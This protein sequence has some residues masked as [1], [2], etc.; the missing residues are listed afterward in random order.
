VREILASLFMWLGQQGFA[1]LPAA[2]GYPAVVRRDGPALLGMVLGEERL[3]SMSDARIRDMS[4]QVAAAY[5]PASGT[6]LLHE[7]L[8]LG[9]VYGRSVLVHELVHLLQFRAR[10]DETVPCLAAL[11]RRAYA[12]Q[13]SYLR[14][15]GETALMDDASIARRSAC[16]P[17]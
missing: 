12:V 2:H 7:A 14:A 8:D 16:P 9:T 3:A 13:R 1:D 6:V 17:S 11:E 15:H 10:A 4:R 5:D